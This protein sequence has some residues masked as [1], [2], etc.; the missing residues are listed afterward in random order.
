MHTKNRCKG[1]KTT[2]KDDGYNN[3]DNNSAVG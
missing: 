3:D 2:D 1:E